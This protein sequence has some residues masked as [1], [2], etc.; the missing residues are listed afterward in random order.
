MRFQSAP[1]RLIHVTFYYRFLSK[2][3]KEL[4]QSYHEFMPLYPVNDFLA[5]FIKVVECRKNL[6]RKLEEKDKMDYQLQL[7]EFLGFAA[8]K[9]GSDG[10]ENKIT[11]LPFHVNTEFDLREDLLVL[12]NQIPNSFRVFG[13]AKQSSSTTNSNSEF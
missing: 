12:D 10:M 4:R 3:Y 2:T 9:L 11:V 7:D 1:F 8:D 13:T 5:D 6:N